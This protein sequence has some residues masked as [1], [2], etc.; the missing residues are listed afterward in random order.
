MLSTMYK[1]NE[2]MFAGKNF[3]LYYIICPVFRIRV[4]L[5]GSG[6]D[7]ISESGSGSRQNLDP[8]QKSGSGSIKK[9]ALK[10]YVQVNKI[11]KKNY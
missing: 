2:Q 7:F 1:V 8:I 10:F 9:N 3:I 11:K 6:S 5:S 4:L